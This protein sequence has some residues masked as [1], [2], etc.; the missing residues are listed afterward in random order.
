MANKKITAWFIIKRNGTGYIKSLTIFCANQKQARE[1]VRYYAHR[2]CNGAHPFSI[3]FKPPVETDNGLLWGDGN[4]YTR[5]NKVTQT[6][7]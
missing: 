6:L 4:L 2:D 5:Y 7:W 1:N 3:T